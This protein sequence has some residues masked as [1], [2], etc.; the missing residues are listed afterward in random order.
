MRRF[1]A[2]ASLLLSAL[3]TNLG[4]GQVQAQE[5]APSRVITA[6]A[7]R[8]P[9][10]APAPV[11]PRPRPSIRRPGPDTPGVNRPAAP[12]STAQEK[13][14]VELSEVMGALTF[15][16]QLCTPGSDPNPWR[17][18]METLLEAEGESSGTH[19]RMA[20]AYNTGFADYATTY[21]QC[22]PAAQAA[23]QALVREAARLARDLERRFG[24]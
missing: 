9:A 15:L 16:S 2:P 10:A 3:I 20:G 21:R 12:L 18:R 7:A 1:L 13:P 14:L 8:P 11:T 4:A 24:S 5:G 19:D 6:P 17:R 23:Q 22:T